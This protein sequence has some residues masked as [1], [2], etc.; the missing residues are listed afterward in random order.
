MANKFIAPGA[1]GK[2]FEQGLKQLQ[3]RRDLNGAADLQRGYSNGAT[4]IYARSGKYYVA[5]N[6]SQM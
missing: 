5:Y 3:S 2:G 4:R 6:F 1:L